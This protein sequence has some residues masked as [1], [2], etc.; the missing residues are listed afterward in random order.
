MSLI[1]KVSQLNKNFLRNNYI[2]KNK[3]IA[4]NIIKSH[5]FPRYAANSH[6]TIIKNLQ[7]IFIFLIIINIINTKKF[8]SKASE[9]T[10]KI[11]G[12]GEQFVLFY[13]YENICPDFIYINDDTTINRLPNTGECNKT[14]IPH[15]SNSDINTVRLVWSNA[16]LTTARDILKDLVNVIEIDLSKFDSSEITDMDFMFQR[17]HSLTS[18]NLNNF[19]TSK[20]KRM[21]CMFYECIQLTE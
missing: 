15:N 4:N 12:D 6:I 11:R 19:N 9:I 14:N 13:G 8:Y 7:F 18:I 16:K 5:I 21:E 20:V 3:I 1:Q 10:L 17:D 2:R